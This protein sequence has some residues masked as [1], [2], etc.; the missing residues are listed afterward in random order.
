MRTALPE[1]RKFLLI[2]ALFCVAAAAAPADAYEIRIPVDYP[3]IQEGIDAADWGDTVTVASGTYTGSGNTNLYF[4]GKDIMLRAEGRLPTV[5]DCQ[6]YIPR[7]GI[8]FSKG[9]SPAA[10]LEGFTFTGGHHQGGGGILCFSYSSP[11]IV[12]CLV[13]G[14]YSTIYGGGIYCDRSDPVFLNCTVT[15][16]SSVENSRGSGIY[17][18]ESNPVLIDCTISGNGP[19]EGFACAYSDPV[20][21][22]CTIS[23]NAWTGFCALGS[24][25]IVTQCTIT[26]NA[27]EGHGGGIHGVLLGGSFTDCDISNNTA[28]SLFGDPMGGAFYCLESDPYI[29]NCILWSDEPDEIYCTGSLV[30]TVRYSDIGGGWSGSGNI[31]ADP[32]FVHPPAGDYHINVSSPCID[33]GT[34]S[35]APLEDFET[36]PRPTGD[37]WDMGADEYVC[38]LSVVLSGYP[39]VIHPEET[40]SFTAA[41]V[42]ECDEPLPFDKARMMI[43]GPAGLEKTLYDGSDVVL[44]PGGEASAPVN[45]YVPGT[46]PAGVYTITVII[47]R[48]FFRRFPIASDAFVLEVLE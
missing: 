46:A 40:L 26:G 29:T 45:L 23:D 8:S 41:A 19:Y 7:R 1:I 25:P 17:C 37:G 44:P 33:T 14:N 36:D 42:N 27:T 32:M 48:T 18:D 11:T 15:N 35:G 5:I 9:E 16:N 2:A 6:G 30:P 4:T 10:V 20:L 3:T 28:F 39:V 21:Q 38:D 12:D 43:V 22:N 24:D 47:Y 13:S 34:G 31:D